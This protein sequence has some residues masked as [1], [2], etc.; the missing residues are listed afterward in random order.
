[1]LGAIGLLD[2]FDAN[3]GVR[4]FG[5][6]A[7]VTGELVSGGR[8]TTATFVAQ[9]FDDSDTYGTL[10]TRLLENGEFERAL[11]VV[12]RFDAG[13]HNFQVTTGRIADCAPYFL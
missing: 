9:Y 2:A 11:A 5:I 1:M 6:H 10:V 7:G 12:D 3:P 8:S 4:L 13:Q